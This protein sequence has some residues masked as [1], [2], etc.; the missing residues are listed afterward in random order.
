[1]AKTIRMLVEVISE[2]CT[3]CNLCSRVCPTAAITL[4]DRLPS[5]NGSSRKIV[6]IDTGTCYNAQRCLELCPDDALRMVQLPMPFMVGFD[7]ALADGAAV[8][9]LCARTG[10]PALAPVCPCTGT[11]MGELAAAVL[12]GADTPEKLSLATGVRTGCSELCMHPVLAI[13]GAA[14]HAGMPKHSAKGYQ[15]YAIA[16][17]L[18]QQIGADGKLPQALLDKY[19]EYHLEREIA[20]LGRLRAAASN[21]PQEAA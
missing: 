12:A 21:P 2:K 6:E 11:T 8:T 7:M 19:P 10:I 18:F 3:G 20:D 1:M 17:T 4:R 13:L 9:A 16:P 14:G 5:E 15:S